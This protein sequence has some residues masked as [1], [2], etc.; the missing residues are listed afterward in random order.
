MKFPLRERCAK[1]FDNMLVRILICVFVPIFLFG[2]LLVSQKISPVSAY[3]TIFTS[4]FG[5][6]YTMGEV[7]IRAT[8]LIL[9]AMAAILPARVGLANAGGEGDK[10]TVRG[11]RHPGGCCADRLQEYR[12][13]AEI[14][15]TGGVRPVLESPPDRRET[16]PGRP[17]GR[18]N[19]RP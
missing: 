8:Y 3:S 7:V 13:G 17:E 4:V 18:G 19:P 9:T 1:L 5:S 16:G 2:I 15:R 12:G 11:S 14:G 6:A 10:G